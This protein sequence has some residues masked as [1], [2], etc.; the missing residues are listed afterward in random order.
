MTATEK[1]T[2]QISVPAPK[3]LARKMRLHCVANDES[4]RDFVL[5]AIEERL[6]RLGREAGTR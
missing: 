1:E 4:V 3:D 2:T 6:E 5:R